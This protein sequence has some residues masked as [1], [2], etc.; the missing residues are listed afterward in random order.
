[1]IRRAQVG[2]GQEHERQ[3]LA[4]IGRSGDL[5]PEHRAEVVE[6]L[7]YLSIKWR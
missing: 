1:M 2:L 7:K 6:T 4:A 5:L 3:D